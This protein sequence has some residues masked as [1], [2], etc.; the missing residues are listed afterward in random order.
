MKEGISYHV[1]P[2]EFEHF[3]NSLQNRVTSNDKNDN[4]LFD[5]RSLQFFEMFN[6][7]FWVSFN[8][9]NSDLS[10]ECF[11][12]EQDTLQQRVTSIENMRKS[13]CTV[14]HRTKKEK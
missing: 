7:Q 13:R 6:R 9:L 5:Y 4:T 2:H 14:R 3:C 8:S 1:T 11:D 12:R 10:I